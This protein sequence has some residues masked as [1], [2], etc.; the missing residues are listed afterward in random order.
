MIAT[1]FL[2][3]FFGAFST[4]RKASSSIIFASTN[5]ATAS[6]IQV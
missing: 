2:P 5:A 1:T 4:I 3:Q 6:R